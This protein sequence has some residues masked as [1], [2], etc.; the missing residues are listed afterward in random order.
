LITT[1]SFGAD[2]SS[3][4]DYTPPMRAVTDCPSGFLPAVQ[5]LAPRNAQLQVQKTMA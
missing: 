4:T 2:F 5:K 3:L 1:A